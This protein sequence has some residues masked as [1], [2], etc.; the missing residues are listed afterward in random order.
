MTPWRVALTFDLEH[1]DR[2]A[3]AGATDRLLD[4]LDGLD[5]PATLFLQGRWAEAYPDTARRI[6]SSGH[7]VGN[8]SHYH[9]R[10]PLLTDAGIGED[11]QAAAAA[12]GEFAGADPRPWFRLPFGAGVDDSRVLAAIA[13]AGYRDVG[14]DVDGQDWQVGRVP[15]EL[16][17][18]IVTGATRH[19]DGAIVLLHGWPDPT[20]EALPRIVTRLRDAGAAFVRIDE[21]TPGDRMMTAG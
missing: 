11:L 14:W 7:L 9:A 3:R 8:H 4:V 18:D 12:I 16:E 2:P 19:G 20:A 13:D 21:R 1:P 10:M 17:T 6:G 5:V 15:A